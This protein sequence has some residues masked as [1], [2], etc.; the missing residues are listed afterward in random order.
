MVFDIVLF[1]TIDPEFIMSRIVD[2][3]NDELQDRVVHDNSFATDPKDDMRQLIRKLTGL[4]H[5][6]K[7]TGSKAFIIIDALNKVD[8][9]GQTMKVSK[10]NP[11]C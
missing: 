9:L 7:E 1:D 5:R 3:L 2:E 6:V 11:C 10:T 4:M 8:R